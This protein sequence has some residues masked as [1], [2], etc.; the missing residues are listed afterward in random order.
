MELNKGEYIFAKFNLKLENAKYFYIP[1]LNLHFYYAEPLTIRIDIKNNILVIG[2]VEEGSPSKKSLMHNL[3]FFSNITPFEKKKLTKSWVGR[4]LMLSDN[5]ILC[6]TWSSYTV[7]KCKSIN[8]ILFCSLGL[9]KRFNNLN[10]LDDDLGFDFTPYEGDIERLGPM[11]YYDVKR[12]YMHEYEDGLFENIGSVSSK[13]LGQILATHTETALRRLDDE[14]SNGVFLLPLTSGRDSRMSLSMCLNALPSSRFVAY[15]FHKPY[16]AIT[17]SD[18]LMPWLLS[19]FFKFNYYYVYGSKQLKNQKT[20][21]EFLG[22][23]RNL[24]KKPGDVGYYIIRNYFDQFEGYNEKIVI[25]SLFYD[26]M[27]GTF[28]NYRRKNS[29][30]TYT[31]FKGR[32]NFEEDCEKFLT[33]LCS[34]HDPDYVLDQGFS[35]LFARH[36]YL[37][38][39]MSTYKFIGAD[40]FAPAISDTFNELALNTD[41]R[42]LKRAVVHRSAIKKA[43]KLLAVIPFNPGPEELG[44]YLHRIK[45][46]WY[47]LLKYLT[48]R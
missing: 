7:Y 16:Y 21:Q 8:S 33:Q 38:K 19:K 36:K 30:F 37:E 35:Y 41:V 9:L 10:E 14:I 27:E 45:R 1:W 20:L 4:W 32:K 11:N 48:N 2:L 15:T 29:W 12:D 46:A 47:Y 40:V 31:G 43:S 17:I 24:N 39:L 25:T 23:K 28:A 18:Y 34:A 26:L 5:Y 13:E 3:A 44:I 42:E 22:T 6:D